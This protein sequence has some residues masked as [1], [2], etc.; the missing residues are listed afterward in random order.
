MKT[1]LF[2]HGFF[3]AGFCP[4]ARALQDALLGKAIVIPPDIP[5]DPE[6]ALSVI[7]GMCDVVKPDLLVGNSCGAFYAQILSPI[8]GIPALLGNPHFRMSEFLSERIGMHESK[9]QRKKEQSFSVDEALIGKFREIEKTQFDN[10]CDYRKGSV[11]GIFGEKDTLAGFEPLFL[12][13]YDNSYH[14][15][16][17][18]TPTPEE[19]KKYYAPLCGK[20]MEEYPRKEGERRFFLHFKGGKYEMTGTALDSETM[21]KMVIYRALYGEKLTWVRPEKMF[22][23]MVEKEGKKIHRFTEV[24]GFPDV[25]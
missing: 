3:S 6:E 1:I 19:V 16:G 24:E 23:S 11:W 20:L 7:E 5:H 4:Q 9:F 25:K 2:L 18:H 12:E 14:F 15:P 22:F 21:E 17:N 13:H 10:C 8:L